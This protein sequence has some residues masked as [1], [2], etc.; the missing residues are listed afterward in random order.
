MSNVTTLREK[1]DDTRCRMCLYLSSRKDNWR[2]FSEWS[3]NALQG[4]ASAWRR[5]R[6]KEECSA[7]RRK[8]KGWQEEIKRFV[9]TLHTHTH[10]FD[11]DDW[12]SS[13]LPRQAA[14]PSES[15]TRKKERWRYYNYSVVGVFKSNWQER[16]SRQHFYVKL[17]YSRVHHFSFF[18][19]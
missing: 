4:I 1:E 6:R 14:G 8:L 3:W 17:E 15:K 9:Y 7:T 10:T 11:G 18:F 2:M 16:Q 12:V 19:L 13:R 5:R